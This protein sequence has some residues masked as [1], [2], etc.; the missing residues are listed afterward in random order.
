MLSLVP[1]IIPR[2]L[3]KKCLDAV[4][5]SFTMTTVRCLY[6]SY[7]H[8]S[9]PMWDII[10]ALTTLHHK[11]SMYATTF[12]EI[13]HEG[14]KNMIGVQYA[15]PWSWHVLILWSLNHVI[16]H[17]S[18]LVIL[19]FYIHI[20]IFMQVPCQSLGPITRNP[21]IY[22][23]LPCGFTPIISSIISSSFYTSSLPWFYSQNLKGM[24]RII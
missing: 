7:V 20:I 18:H 15:T 12:T 8:D 11:L 13:D 22:P 6:I 24:P 17:P 2:N 16:S 14:T 23:S 3:C 21:H 5:T 19:A 4:R 1:Y 9:T 10:D